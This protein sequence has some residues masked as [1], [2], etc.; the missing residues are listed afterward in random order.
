MIHFVCSQPRVRPTCTCTCTAQSA[1]TSPRSHIT[2]SALLTSRSHLLV[3]RR[4]GTPPLLYLVH[5]ADS[6]LSAS[7]RSARSTADAGAPSATSKPSTSPT[8]GPCMRPVSATRTGM[9]SRLP[10]RFSP[11]P[12]PLIHPLNSPF[13]TAAARSPLSNPATT[14]SAISPKSSSRIFFIFSSSTFSF[15]GYSRIART[16]DDAACTSSMPFAHSSTAFAVKGE[17]TD[18][19]RPSLTSTAPTIATWSS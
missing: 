6:A 17:S 16:S 4:T 1:L 10:L 15:N 9:N 3:H 18:A 11:L 13:A 14:A 2:V 7:M 5:A 19:A 12:T 8:S